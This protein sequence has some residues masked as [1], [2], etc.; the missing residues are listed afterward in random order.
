MG[1]VIKDLNGYS[2]EEMQ[3]LRIYDHSWFHVTRYGGYFSAHNHPMASWSGV[4]CVFPG[5]ARAGEQL[6][7][8]LR[9]MEARPTAGMYLDPGNAYL[10][11]PYAFGDIPYSLPAG[12]LVLFPSYLHHEVTPFWG[13][14]ERI[15][16]AF[17]CWVRY[18]DQPIDEPEIRMR[19]QAGS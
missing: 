10:K 1:Q 13:Q 16:V 12:A 11:L 2:V 8:Q 17:N 9:F 3:K 4:Y 15:T 7:G 6:G 18:A 5:T 19:Q 14:D